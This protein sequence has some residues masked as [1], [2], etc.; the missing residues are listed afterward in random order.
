MCAA[1]WKQL[2]CIFKRSGRIRTGPTLVKQCRRV[3]RFYAMSFQVDALLGKIS[4]RAETPEL[5]MYL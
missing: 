4:Q 1:L 5:G 3:L 2:Q